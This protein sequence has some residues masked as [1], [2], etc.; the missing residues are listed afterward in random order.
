MATS[1]DGPALERVELV[2][3]EAANL[4]WAIER[5]VEGPLG[6]AVDRAD[7][8]HAAHPPAEPEPA[9]EPVGYA[10]QAWRYR[11]ESES[12]PWWIPLV[13]E[14]MAQGSAQT[15]LRR[16]RMAAWDR[17]DDAHVGP[18]GALLE[19]AAPLTLHEE[20]VP[21]SGVRVER[22]WQHARWVDGSVH[23]WQQRRKRRGRG[24]RSSGLRWDALDR[25]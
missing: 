21:R 22:A 2:R 12:P 20:E 4:A 7:A 8:W 3:D 14:R 19:P 16:A 9:G 17:L 15:R 6:R 18:K 10:D 11:L 25:A 1:L 13:P 24:E 23:V 5:L